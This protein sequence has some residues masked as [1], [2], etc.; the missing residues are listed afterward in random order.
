MRMRI[1]ST[2]TLS[3]AVS[4]TSCVQGSV[5]AEPTLHSAEALD[6]ADAAS[7]PTGEAALDWTRADC[8]AA[9][10]HNGDLCNSSPPNVRPACFAAAATMLAACLAA[11]QG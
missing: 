5:G 10:Q 2:L 8:I 7:E 1:L 11:A 3:C 6:R 9:W 4:A